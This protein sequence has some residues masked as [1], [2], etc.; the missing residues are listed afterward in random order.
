MEM[1]ILD[2]TKKI[3]G[4]GP[5]YTPF[6]LDIITHINSVFSILN[7]MGIGNPN[8]FFIDGDQETWYDYAGVTIDPQTGVIWD[9]AFISENMLSM[10]RTYVF[11]KVRLLFDPPNT[12]FLIEAMNNQISEYEWRLSTFREMALAEQEAL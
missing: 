6:D 7:Q 12:S 8:G 5:E 9:N 4:L 3:L 11:L 1:S 10:I 2:S